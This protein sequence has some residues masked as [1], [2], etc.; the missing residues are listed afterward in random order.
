VRARLTA[1]AAAHNQGASGLVERGCAGSKQRERGRAGAHSHGRRGRAA[2]V[3]VRSCARPPPSA[4]ARSAAPLLVRLASLI[5]RLRC[6]APRRVALRRVALPP[7]PRRC[8]WSSR[9]C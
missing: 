2:L 9:S 3:G 7:A 8:S 1:V 6:A 5:C 4:P